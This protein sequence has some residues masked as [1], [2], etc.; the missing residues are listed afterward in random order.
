VASLRRD[1]GGADHFAPVAISTLIC[2]A[3][4]SGERMAY[5]LCSA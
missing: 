4:A 2:L 5:C 1:V 3:N